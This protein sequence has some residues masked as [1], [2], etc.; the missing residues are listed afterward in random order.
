MPSPFPG[1]DP[2]LETA[3][4]WLSFHQTLIA[5]LVEVLQPRRGLSDQYQPRVR[6][7][8]YVVEGEHR[9]EYIEIIRGFGSDT[10]LVT[11]LDVVSPSNKTTAAGREAFL[12]TWE[13]GKAAGANLVEIDLVLQGQPLLDYSREGLPMWDYEVTVLRP[14][15]PERYEIYTS[16]LQK[17]LPRFKLP[18]AVNERDTVVD[19]QAAFTR[20]Y[21]Q[22]GFSTQIDYREAPAVPLRE[23]NRQFLDKLL[24][25][26]H[27]PGQLESLHDR[28]SVAAYY[29]WRQEGCPHGRDKEHWYM[30]VEQLRKNQQLET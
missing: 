24:G 25:T 17:R 11:L 7:R 29:Q 10:R 28:I 16:T 8:R 12:G 22:G 13:Q 1:M 14:A 18:L 21:D 5:C 27:F 26:Q 4:L 6:E 9:E 19:L 2:Y 3:S 30:A 23:E 20:C 15:K